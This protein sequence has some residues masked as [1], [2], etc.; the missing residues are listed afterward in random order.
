M[1]RWPTVQLRAQAPQLLTFV[2][3]L[4]HSPPQSVNPVPHPGGGLVVQPLLT[5]FCPAGQ[6]LAHLPQLLGSEAMSTHSLPQRILP[7][8]QGPV[9]SSPVSAQAAASMAMQARSSK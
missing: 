3:R 9:E 7:D 8:V 4:T 5:Q 1:H 2:L 6:T